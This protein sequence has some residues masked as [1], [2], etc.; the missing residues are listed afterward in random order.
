VSADV[1]V[2]DSSPLILLAR[3]GHLDLLRKLYERVIVPTAVW[4]EVTGSTSAPGAVEVISSKWIIVQD[5]PTPSAD[6]ATEVDD[7]E[8]EAIS[9]ALSMPAC[10]LLV[11]DLAAREL[12]RARHVRVIGTLGVLRDAKAAG[13]TGPLR[14]LIEKLRA[15]EFRV[16]EELVEAFCRAVGE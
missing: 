6:I 2:A 4:H 13:L 3:T 14:P 11:D 5:A 7:G 10:L 9:L 15:N 8:A 16:S 1:V 12:A